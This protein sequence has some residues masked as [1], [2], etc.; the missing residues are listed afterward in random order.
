MSGALAKRT[1]S[2]AATEQ[3]GAA[4]ASSL[5][6]GDVIALKGPLGG[7]KTCFVRGLARG[8]AAP[9]RVRSPTF[10]LVNEYAGRLPLYHL[11]LY[12]LETHD[13]PD[14]GLEDY[15]DAG[16]LAV[17]WGERLPAS[18]L[19]DALMLAFE[20]PDAATRVIQGAAWGGRGKALLDVWRAL[21]ADGEA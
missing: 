14:L 9:S 10:T 6:V 15:A 21:D 20:I 8:L 4:L 1:D 5:A 19:E 7:G 3:L 12:R 13:V 11:D 18:W 16:V 17:E 2:A